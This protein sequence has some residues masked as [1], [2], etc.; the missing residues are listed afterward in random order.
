MAG[1]LA[2]VAAAPSGREYLGRI[3]GYLK[4]ALASPDIA[5][6]M[7]GSRARSN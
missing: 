2:K 4:W 7:Y 3:H 6:Y 1:L 5:G